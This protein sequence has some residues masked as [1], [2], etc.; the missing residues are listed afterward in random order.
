MK[1]GK[2]RIIFE[3]DEKTK[4]IIILHIGLRKDGYK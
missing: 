3:V 4:E 2:Y 1:S